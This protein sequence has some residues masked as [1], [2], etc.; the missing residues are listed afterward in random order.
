MP[1]EFIHKLLLEH[2]EVQ[3]L[4]WQSDSVVSILRKRRP[5][6]QAAILKLP[7]VDLEHV[8]PFL[9]SPVSV[10]SNFPRIGKWS[11][12]AIEQCE[13]AGK[14]W[15]QWVVLLKAI[16]SDYPE[17]TANP[18]ISFSRRALRQHSRVVGVSFVFDHLLLVHHEN[19]KRLRVALLYEYDLTG[20]DVRGAWDH[21]G[22]FDV[23][24]KTNPNGSILPEAYQVSEA[25]GAKVFGIKDTLGYLA[26]GKF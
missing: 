24:L 12:G 22:A 25:L 16:S 20:D 18:E 11:G 13:A 4:D 1:D 10:I 19:G 3:A 26:R 21:L 7:L 8:E 17:T 2:T 15:G 6:F 9:D 14:A 23:L 5:P